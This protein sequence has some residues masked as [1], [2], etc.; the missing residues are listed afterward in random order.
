MN[1]H[2]QIHTKSRRHALAELQDRDRHDE[3]EGD[4]RHPVQEQGPDQILRREAHAL[5]E[6]GPEHG[7]RGR[8]EPEA[9]EEGQEE[10]F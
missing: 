9:E 10:H 5:G 3:H 1:T 8:V 4:A 7:L 2:T 6:P